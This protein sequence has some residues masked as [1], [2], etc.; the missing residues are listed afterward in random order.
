MILEDVVLFPQMMLPLF[1][2]EPRYRDMLKESLDGSRMFC[3]ARRRVEVDEECPERVAGLGLVRVALDHDN[4]TS[5][6]VLQG[7][8]RVI[9]R[10]RGQYRTFPNYEIRPLETK[11]EN[12]E[13]VHALS[14]RVK[15]IAE[16]LLNGTSGEQECLVPLMTSDKTQNNGHS[17]DAGRARILEYLKYMEDP[18]QIGDLVASSLVRHSDLKQQLLAVSS[19]EE[20]LDFLAKCL[21]EENNIRNE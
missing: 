17:E 20:R 13:R 14:L 5:H 16:N 1:I 2:F 15:Q 19:L 12:D 7:I 9:L 6:L 8:S 3:V 18:E 10:S 4:G 11:I 21:I